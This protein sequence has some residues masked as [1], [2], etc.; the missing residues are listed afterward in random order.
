MRVRQRGRWF[1]VAH[2][3]PWL[4]FVSWYRICLAELWPS[5]AILYLYVLG[6]RMPERSALSGAGKSDS[7]PNVVVLFMNSLRGSSAK[8]YDTERISMAPAHG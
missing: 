6:R 4:R 8:F 7:R 3:L 2:Q 5:L 1:A